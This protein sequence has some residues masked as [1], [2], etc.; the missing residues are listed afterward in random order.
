MGDVI[1]ESIPDCVNTF[2]ST[3]MMFG[4]GPKVHKCLVYGD[5]CIAARRNHV[6]SV[7][8][9]GGTDF[10]IFLIVLCMVCREVRSVAG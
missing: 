8:K 10:E 6:F 7:M 2:L 3:G 9:S 5:N 1:R 4:A